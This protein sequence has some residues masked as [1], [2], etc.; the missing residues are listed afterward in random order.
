MPKVVKTLLK[1]E[2]G[3]QLVKEKRKYKRKY[4]SIDVEYDISSDQKWLESKSMN[5]SS[6]GICLI[7]K[8]PMHIGKIFD[9]K[10][11]IP[12]SD[13]LIKVAGKIIWNEK[14]HEKDGEGYY[15]GIQFTR[16]HN[17]DRMLISKFIDSGTFE[18]K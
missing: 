15:N 16:I 2:A 6:G 7:T 14:C 1:Y 9:M 3:E 8:E 17:E 13:K 4:I 10:F 12:D 11:R 5:I 18:K